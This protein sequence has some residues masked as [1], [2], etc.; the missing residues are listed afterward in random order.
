MPRA[1]WRRVGATAGRLAPGPMR[2]YYR[3]VVRSYLASLRRQEGIR[4]AYAYGSFVGGNFRPGRSDVDFVSVTEAATAADEVELLLQLRGPYR[5]HQGLLPIDLWEFPEAEFAQTARWVGA[6]RP[7]AGER[8]PRRSVGDWRLLWGE[9]FR[10]DGIEEADPRLATV[11]DYF[12]RAALGQA[13]QGRELGAY[14]LE[15]EH[16]VEREGFDWPSL[17]DLR[18]SRARLASGGVDVAESE[19]ALHATLRVVEDHRRRH[20]FPY[21]KYLTARDD[22][23]VPA[24][25]DAAVAAAGVLLRGCDT[26]AAATVRSATLYVPLALDDLRPVL[27]L[28]CED[29]DAATPLIAWIVRAGVDAARRA[30]LELHLVTSLLAEDL[31]RSPLQAHAVIGG[32]RCLLG[33]EL[34]GRV[35]LPAKPWISDLAQYGGFWGATSIRRSLLGH[36]NSKRQDRWP[37][38]LAAERRLA[39]GEPPLLDAA[40]L[41]RETPE[42]R[43]V[44]SEDPQAVRA[45]RDRDWA[46]LGLE[47]WRGWPG[48]REST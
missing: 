33:E 10:S 16:D 20:A 14:L 43:T 4:A 41:M 27:L 1:F 19:A 47:I 22:W 34:A 15:L 29:A 31:W 13:G 21:E 8:L 42:L 24:P 37:L 35:G 30:G 23:R 28:E 9:E 12:I 39:A 40:A 5:R 46:R 48:L 2:A 26:R 44:G 3:A 7:R 18:R 36:R 38:H 6:M 32:G 25:D 17:Q 11:G 45:L